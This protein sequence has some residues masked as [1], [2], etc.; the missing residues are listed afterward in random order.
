MVV[1]EVEVEHTP[2]QKNS[3]VDILSKLATRKGK[4]KHN[5]VVYL[6]FPN[7]SVSLEECLCTETVPAD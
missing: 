3:R 5:T 6:N 4:G 2:R 7:L 1:G